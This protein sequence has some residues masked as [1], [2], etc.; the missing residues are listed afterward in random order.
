M[1]EHMKNL[2]K[3]MLFLPQ[4]TKIQSKSTFK[5]KPWQKISFPTLIWENPNYEHKTPKNIIQ[6]SKSMKRVKDYLKDVYGM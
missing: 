6:G 3:Y 2:P 5:T 4:G 1:H